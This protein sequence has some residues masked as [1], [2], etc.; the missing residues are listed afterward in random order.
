MSN[1]Q[2]S[3]FSRRELMQKTGQVAV[4]SAL[5]ESVGA[6]MLI[7]GLGTRWATL[8]IGFNL[9]VAVWLE[10]SKHSSSFELPA[11]YLIGIAAIGVAGAGSYSLDA[12]RSP[13]RKAKY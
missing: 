4:A 1:T 2:E 13:R 11:V 9:A 3:G 7:V 6:V 8:A 12:R 5:A 10:L